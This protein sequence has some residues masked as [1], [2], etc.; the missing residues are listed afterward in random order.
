MNFK[1]KG[2]RHAHRTVNQCFMSTLRN[3]IESI[4]LAYFKKSDTELISRYLR[5]PRYDIGHFVF[6]TE[7]QD[8]KNQDAKSVVSCFAFSKF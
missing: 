3:G 2:N 6:Q 8:V 1:N 4:I 5:T 7:C